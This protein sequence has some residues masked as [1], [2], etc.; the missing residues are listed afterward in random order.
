MKLGRL[1][2]FKHEHV[3]SFFFGREDKETEK[4]II[5]GI[6]CG[7]TKE[8]ADRSYFCRHKFIETMKYIKEIDDLDVETFS[9]AKKDIIKTMKEFVK[10]F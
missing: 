1:K 2:E 4:M 5:D 6:P 9:K 8:H 7:V 10:F 3:R